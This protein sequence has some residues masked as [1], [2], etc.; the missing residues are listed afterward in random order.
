MKSV[1]AVL[2]SFTSVFAMAGQLK[3]VSKIKAATIMVQ[4]ISD[5]ASRERGR[6]QQLNELFQIE[7]AK[8]N[9]YLDKAVLNRAE[10]IEV[11][12]LIILVSKTVFNHRIE[13]SMHLVNNETSNEQI[14]NLVALSKSELTRSSG[15]S[16]LDREF[17]TRLEGLAKV[18]HGEG[19]YNLSNILETIEV[20]HAHPVTLPAPRKSMLAAIRDAAVSTFRL[21]RPV[22]TVTDQAN[23]EAASQ[24]VEQSVMSF[25][26]PRTLHPTTDRFG[27][28]TARM[29]NKSPFC[30]NFL[31]PDDNWDI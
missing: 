12:E 18:F 26:G 30:E 17:R 5:R 25:G 22:G 16:K 28:V 10:A 8:V 4:S 24:A 2:I 20:E 14:H 21:I 9:D 13:H 7:I 19:K 11:R 31:S 27:K 1:F 23:A 29:G 3:P 6:S 15:Q